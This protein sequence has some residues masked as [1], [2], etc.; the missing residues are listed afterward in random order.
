MIDDDQLLDHGWQVG[1][2]PGAQGWKPGG[3]GDG[4]EAAALEVL[5]ANLCAEQRLAGWYAACGVRAV[6]PELGRVFAGL[7]ADASRRAA[8][9]TAR[10]RRAVEIDPAALPG[11]L[12]M[13]LWMTRGGDAGPGRDGGPGDG[14]VPNAAGD[15]HCI[16]WM[17]GLYRTLLPDPCPG[18]RG[19]R[20]DEV[21]VPALAV[22][23]RVLAR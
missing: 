10:L 19:A 12:R 18:T 14:R 21:P 17:L 23:S 4:G 8:A 7:A 5:T 15:R 9:W 20:A 2:I 16:G 1:S 3:A 11:V 22:L 13:A 6:D